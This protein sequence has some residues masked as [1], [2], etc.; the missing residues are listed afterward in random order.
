[1]DAITGLS[2]TINTQTVS[3]VADRKGNSNSAI[4]F[5]YGSAL[6]PS[7][8]YF[9]GSAFSIAGWIYMV[10]TVSSTSRL[11][12]C[13]ST[14]KCIAGCD[15]VVLQYNSI[16][17][18]FNNGTQYYGRLAGGPAW[19]VGSW[20]HIATTVSAAAAGNLY[21]NGTVAVSGTVALPRAVTRDVCYL[22]GS[23]WADGNANA[24]FD[25]VIIF[26]TELSATNVQFVMNTYFSS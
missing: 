25:D 4:Y 9:S 5:N 26:N 16:L 3:F 1:M 18:I 20:T 10:N 24:Y 8:T 14:V 11:L 7:A 19:P 13:G 21:V 12:D 6:L 15:N 22:S 23:N 17:T 2:F